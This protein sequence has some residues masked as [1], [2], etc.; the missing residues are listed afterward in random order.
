[1]KSEVFFI[2]VK[3]GQS[4][5][6]LAS[7]SVSLL[8]QSGLAE[9][10]KQDHLVAVKQHFG[11]KSDGNYV[12]PAITAKLVQLLKDRGAR[13]FITDTTTLYRGGRADGQAYAQSAYAN[14][15]TYE[16]I[17]APFIIADGLRGLDAVSVT[18]DGK[19]FKQ[20]GIAGAVYHADSVLVVTHVTGHMATCFGGAIKNVGMGVASRSGKLLQH[21]QAIPKQDHDKCVAC[22]ACLRWCPADAIELVSDSKRR[23]ARINVETCIGC[24][25]CLA[26]CPACA[27]IFDWSTSGQALSERMAEHALG[28]VKLKEGKAVYMNYA[29]QIT[30]N[31]DCCGTEKPLIEAVGILASSDLLACE[32]ATVDIINEKVGED[33]FARL[34]PD[35]E[36]ETQLEYG[37][38]IGLGNRD[39]RL[40]TI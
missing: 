37:R 8:Q 33:F 20:V 27:M 16:A 25:E 18:V 21:S 17:G 23:Y 9:I 14:G 36:Y 32:Q 26:V 40:V 22:G 31:C 12:K 28:F 5:S 3:Q 2:P 11:E 19:H 34:W 30:K 13:P 6:S 38:K 29:V 15:F 1:M 7:D 24:G 35:G 39:Y 10:F 4:L